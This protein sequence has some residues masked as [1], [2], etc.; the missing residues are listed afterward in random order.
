VPRPS[1]FLERMTV[2][3][4]HGEILEAL[5]HRG[6]GEQPVVLAPGHPRLYGTMDSPVLAELA[7]AL[8]QH[9]H[10]TLRFNYRGIGAST[11]FSELPPLLDREGPVEAAALQAPYEDLEAA[12]EQQLATTH[13]PNC[14]VVGFSFGAALALRAALEHPQVNRV[15]LIAPPVTRLPFAFAE[16]A[17]TGVAAFVV[18]GEEDRIAAPDVVAVAMGS[19][20]GVHRVPRANHEFSRGLS[21]L[22][23]YVAGTFPGAL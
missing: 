19:G 3:K 18:C 22:G 7:W 11:G 8:S 17:H 12:I 13:E 9:G 2:V 14:A 4:S 5:Y 1:E 16:L 10:P 23:Q 20:M 6:R 15:V 21:L